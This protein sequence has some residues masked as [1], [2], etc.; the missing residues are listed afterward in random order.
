MLS[1]L[2][3]VSRTLSHDRVSIGRPAHSR[4]CAHRQQC[5][6]GET[7]LE[8]SVFSWGTQW[9][10]CHCRD[11]DRGLRGHLGEAAAQLRGPGLPERGDITA[12][13]CQRTEGEHC[14]RPASPSMG[15]NPQGARY[16]P[17]GLH[18]VR[19]L[20]LRAEGERDEEEQSA[21]RPRGPLEFAGDSGH[22]GD[23]QVILCPLKQRSLPRSPREVSGQHQARDSPHCGSKCTVACQDELFLG[24]SH[25]HSRPNSL[26]SQQKLFEFK[27]FH[28][29]WVWFSHMQGTAL[30]HPRLSVE[31]PRLKIPL[32][33]KLS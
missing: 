2:P 4:R 25:P 22:K 24:T 28:L 16:G 32:G 3:P 9:G 29:G 11:K 21:A 33:R 10:Q 20:E 12:P 8:E 7:Q 1:R 5:A 18:A 27:G 15:L 6:L 14:N 23:P 13:V 30:G 26:S 17:R 19:R 31:P